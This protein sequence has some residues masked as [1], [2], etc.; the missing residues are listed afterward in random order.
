MKAL[1][2]LLLLLLLIVVAGAIY[3]ATLENSYDVTRTKIIKAPVQVIYNNVNDYKNWPAWSPWIEKEP[4]VN[5]TFGEKTSGK[6]ATHSWKGDVIGEG[7]METLEAKSNESINQKIAFIKP[8]ESE[9]DIYWNFKPVEGGTEVTWGMKGEMDFMFR[10]AMVFQGGMD[11]QIGPDFERGL[12]KLDSVVQADMKKYSITVNELT[13]RG[14]GY[15]LYN[16]TSC[17]IDELETKKQEMMPKVGIYAQ[18]NNI[19]MA[20]APFT[21]YHKF[22]PE[23]NAVI[24]SSAVPV[25]E[26][27]IT[28]SGSGIQ[29]G[30]LKPFKAVKTTLKG[31]Y[32]N[33]KETWETV[34]KYITD[35]G[36]EELHGQPGLEVYLTDP[37]SKPNPA[38]WL[39]EIYIP[40][41]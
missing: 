39:T 29:T 28:E 31:D 23:N 27:V 5:L 9:S 40:V 8:F 26:K 37:I 4:T 16:T 41:K 21:L 25:A 36:L 24:F 13:T 15:Y 30:M 38:D 3:I 20:G 7:G 33:L 12:F 35:N 14:G 2:Y 32:N 17:K 22:D 1:K 11:K 18:K 34:A 6:G 10:A 19:Q